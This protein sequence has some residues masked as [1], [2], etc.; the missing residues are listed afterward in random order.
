MRTYHVVCHGTSLIDKK[1]GMRYCRISVPA[2]SSGLF[3][4]T[5]IACRVRLAA[6]L[7]NAGTAN[8]KSMIANMQQGDNARVDTFSRSDYNL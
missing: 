4:R 6:N 3:R 2:A 1:E 5:G 7:L 8:K